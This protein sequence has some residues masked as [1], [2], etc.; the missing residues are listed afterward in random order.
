MIIKWLM[1]RCVNS[2]RAGWGSLVPNASFDYKNF[3]I[4]EWSDPLFFY[5]QLFGW[6]VAIVDLIFFFCQLPGPFSKFEEGESNRKFWYNWAAQN[7]M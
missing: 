3:L 4:V 6:A 2:C 5:M 7:K 1:P